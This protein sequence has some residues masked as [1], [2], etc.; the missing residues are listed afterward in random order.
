MSCGKLNGPGGFHLHPPGH[1]HD[2]DHEEEPGADLLTADDEA[3]EADA[4]PQRPGLVATAAGHV[5]TAAAGAWAQHGYL[6]KPFSLLP[7][8]EGSEWLIHQVWGGNPLD[9]LAAAAAMAAAGEISTE[10][11]NHVHGAPLTVRV[12]TRMAAAAAGAFMAIGGAGIFD[13]VTASISAGAALVLSGMIAYE[14][15]KYRLR[16]VPVMLEAPEPVA[17]EAPP[18]PDPRMVLFTDTFCQPNGPLAGVAPGNFQE[19]SNGF[20]MDLGL[21]GSRHS[22]SDVTH[23]QVAIAKLYDVIRDDIT[24]GYLPDNRTEN[25]CR[26]VVRKIPAAAGQDAGP[27]LHMWDGTSTY[28]PETGCAEAGYFTDDSPTHYQFHV[29]GSGAS[30]GMLAGAMG[31]GKTTTMHV[32]AGEAGLAKM[33]RYCDAARSCLQCEMER[34]MAVWICDPQA[35]GMSLWRGRADLTGWGPGGS[36]ELLEVTE[37]VDDARGKMLSSLEYWDTD[38]DGKS[39]YNRGKGYF[40]VAVG[41]PLIFVLVDELPVLVN[42]PDVD[43]ARRTMEILLKGVTQWRKRG[44]HLCLASQMLDTSMIGDK[45]LRD[46][47]R[48][49][50]ALSHRADKNSAHMGGILGDPTKLPREI[51][52]AGFLNGFDQRPDMEFATKFAPEVRRGGRGLTDIRHI[53]GLIAQTPLRYDPATDKVRAAWKLPH[54]QV[55]E[56]WTGRPQ[57]RGAAAVTPVSPSVPNPAAVPV[58]GP[59]SVLAGGMAYREDADKVEKALD[60]LAKRGE[61]AADYG[62]LSQMTKLNLGPLMR[63]V[64]ALKANGRVIEAGNKTYKK[65]A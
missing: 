49:F 24:V 55:F 32:L 10:V 23:L 33:C 58:P 12:K 27:V 22:T 63:A 3:S 17:I 57:F 62:R 29:P 13:P 20:M 25:Y 9:A 7:A 36:L 14:K 50:N 51:P 60:D 18:Q 2:H 46:M 45:A 21:T 28:N 19:V 48:Y 30:V 53:A 35:Q 64:E 38:P 15:H 42:N 37:Q 6:V 56:E 40:D 39:R 34:V 43:L 54:Q 5:Q 61:P 1:D 8:V 47:M 65:A 26:L 59:L 41:M 4:G 52:G 16:R 44:I 31:S 11:V